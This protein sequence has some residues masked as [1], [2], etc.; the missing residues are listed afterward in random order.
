MEA[1]FALSFLALA[2]TGMTAAPHSHALSL[3]VDRH[4]DMVE[5]RLIGRSATAQRVRYDAR[6]SGQ[7]NSRTR[8]ATTLAAGHMVTLSTM[9]MSVADHWCVT[10]AVEEDSGRRYDL[11]QGDCR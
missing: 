4:G 10:V 5:V 3:E 8:G 9:R 7:S 1:K 11:R 6:L 2:A